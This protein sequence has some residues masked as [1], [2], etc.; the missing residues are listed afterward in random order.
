MEASQLGIDGGN[1]EVV[2]H[3]DCKFFGNEFE[4]LTNHFLKKGYLESAAYVVFATETF[5]RPER[6]WQAKIRDFRLV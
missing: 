1:D 3:A 4:D 2:K 6:V 5:G